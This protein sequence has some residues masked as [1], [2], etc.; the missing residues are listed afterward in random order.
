MAKLT[1]DTLELA[2]ISNNQSQA[3]H[4]I[5]ACNYKARHTIPAYKAQTSYPSMLSKS[6]CIKGLQEPRTVDKL[7][8]S[9]E[10]NAED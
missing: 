7:W 5:P 4:A 8:G 3:R 10:P 2:P 9:E 1:T 6:H